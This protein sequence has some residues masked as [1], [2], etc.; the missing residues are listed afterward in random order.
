MTL[1]RPPSGELR[2]VK[3]V[4]GAFADFVAARM[5]ASPDRPFRIALSG[6][7]TARACYE[8]LAPA[9]IDWAGLEIFLG[10]ERCVEPADPAANQRLIREALG[11]RFSQLGA[12]HPMSCDDPD[13]YANL[14]ASRPPL[15]LIHLGLG[16]D[17]HTASLF[18]GS[19]GLSAPAGDSVVRNTDPTGHNPLPRLTFTFEAIARSRVV[20]FTVAGASKA[21]ALREVFEGENLP[22]ARVRAPEVVWLCDYEALGMPSGG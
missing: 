1:P 18:P 13:G 7:E 8:R 2:L 6:G 21:A 22:A 17:G 15:D 9:P 4:P 10:D 14:L 11:E 12:F 20:L 3:D 19:A 5:A 16:P